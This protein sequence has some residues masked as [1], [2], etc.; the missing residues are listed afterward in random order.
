MEEIE[1]ARPEQWSDLGDLNSQM[2]NWDA[3]IQAYRWALSGTL[4]PNVEM[5]TCW[6][7]ALAIWLRAGF[8]EREQ[9]NTTLDEWIEIMAAKALYRRMLSIYETK[10]VGRGQPQSHKL[11]Q[12]AKDNLLDTRRYAV[13]LEPDGTLVPRVE[14]AGFDLDEWFARQ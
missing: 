8:H 1:G 9:T 6:N 4:E 14:H 3:A 5:Q 13:S 10:L 2:K 11:Y 12:Y 7:C